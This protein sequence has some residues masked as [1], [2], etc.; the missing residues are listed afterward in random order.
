M[1]NDSGLNSWRQGI[2]IRSVCL[3]ISPET[4]ES[5]WANSAVQQC[6][7]RFQNACGYPLPRAKHS[8]IISKSEKLKFMDK[9]GNVLCILSVSMSSAHSF[10][11][12]VL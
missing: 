9:T 11:V 8:S 2:R 4:P 5:H 1:L 7:E 3:L 10:R 12:S 6:R